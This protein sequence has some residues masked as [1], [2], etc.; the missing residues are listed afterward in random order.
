MLKILLTGATGFIGTNFILRL[1]HKYDITAIVRTS[2]DT[3]NI[4]KY[5]KI[6][7][8]DNKIE[9]LV[10]FCKKECFNSVVH[11]AAYL[12]NNGHTTN[13]INELIHSNLTFGIEILEATKQAEIPFFINTSTFGIY[14]NS[15]DYRPS[16]LYSATKKAFED[17]MVYYSLTSKTVFSNILPFNIYGPNDVKGKLLFALLDKISQTSE[18]LQMSEGNQIV[19]YTHVYDIV[20]AYN[21]LIELIQKDPEFCRDKVFSLKGNERKTLKEVVSIYEEVLEK[22]LNIQWGARPNRELEIMQPWEGGE[23]LPNWKQKISLKKGF[24]MMIK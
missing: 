15:I 12:S 1:H 10:D 9:E 14:C 6:Y 21:I 16:S 17:I 3:S 7:R 4:D 22:K 2:S 8:Y 18:A 24:K 11:L 20:D 19:D 23:Q 13:T 5:C